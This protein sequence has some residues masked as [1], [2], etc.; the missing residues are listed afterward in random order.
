MSYLPSQ[1]LA[2]MCGALFVLLSFCTNAQTVSPRTQDQFRL[3]PLPVDNPAEIREAISPVAESEASRYLTHQKVATIE[4]SALRTRLVRFDRTALKTDHRDQRC[5]IKYGKVTCFD[6]CI[7]SKVQVTLFPGEPMVLV[8]ESVSQSGVD[9]RPSAWAWV[10]KVEGEAN[11]R[12]VIAMA[13]ADGEVTAHITSD[14]GRRYGLRHIEGDVL[15]AVEWDPVA[16]LPEDTDVGDSDKGSQQ[17]YEELIRETQRLYPGYHPSMTSEEWR[18]YLENNPELKEDGEPRSGDDLSSA[19]GSGGNTTIRV[20]A[21][22]FYGNASP[23]TG[24]QAGL[25]TLNSIVSASGINN[26]TFVS[27]GVSDNIFHMG[28]PVTVQ[29]GRSFVTRDGNS[30]MV[31]IRNQKAADLMVGFMNSSDDDCGS[32]DALRAPANSSTKTYAWAV[33]KNNCNTGST[34]ADDSDVFSHEVAHL[35]GAGHDN[36]TGSF[37]NSKAYVGGANKTLTARASVNEK[38]NRILS[39]GNEFLTAGTPTDVIPSTGYENRDAV[40]TNDNAVSQYRTSSATPGPCPTI[41][42]FDVTP[43]CGGLNKAEWGTP[44]LGWTRYELNRQGTQIYMGGENEVKFHVTRGYQMC[45]RACRDSC[46]GQYSCD[47]AIFLPPPCD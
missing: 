23:A 37:S 40:E 4:S 3:P 43:E 22:G 17:E 6:W 8:N 10:G 26:L 42:S 13:D 29:E 30:T 41:P 25:A 12:V 5:V 31:S 9:V 19:K 7:G 2:R 24:L 35:M 45:V 20:G 16:P 21:F 14:E 46:C 44:V 28:L 27:A 39:Q 34:G 38:I 15:M 11:S 47:G 36:L 33:V 32:A 18:Q 1:V